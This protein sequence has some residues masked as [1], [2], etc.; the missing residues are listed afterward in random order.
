MQELFPELQNIPSYIAFAK[1]PNLLLIRKKF[2]NTIRE[3][4]VD[5]TYHKIFQT[6]FK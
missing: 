5:G 1:K 6:Y 3:M 2:D 4:K